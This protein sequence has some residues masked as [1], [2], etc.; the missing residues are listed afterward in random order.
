MGR[1]NCRPGVEPADRNRV[2]PVRRSCDRAHHLSMTSLPAQFVASLTDSNADA[3]F[4]CVV[5]GHRKSRDAALPRGWPCPMRRC[6]ACGLIQQSSR[7]SA[8]SPVGPVNLSLN[9]GAQ[10][11]SEAWTSAVQQYASCL[12]PLE[13]SPGRNLLIV[14]CGRGHLAALARSR[15][16]RVVALDSSPHA[17]CRAIEQFGLDARAGGLARHRE[18]L[19]RFDVVV[20]GNLE[21]SWDPAAVL[22]DTRTVLNTAGLVCVDVSDGFADWNPAMADTSRDSQDAPLNLFNAE[23]L[24]GLLRT[25]GLEMVAV[26]AGG[27]GSAP[28]LATN[29]LGVFRWIP[30]FIARWF[31]RLW[32]L[33][34]GGP[35][36]GCPRSAARDLSEAVAQI[37]A[38]ASRP[39]AQRGRANR[40]LAVATRAALAG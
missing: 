12:L 27:K 25:C 14:G 36:K 10:S 16:W 40:L 11:E 30:R 5:C 7:R 32:S 18:A 34:A 29:G 23:S 2:P 15:G 4:V 38:T 8:R 22:R 21:T 28:Q 17:V 31:S 37:E 9:G 35:A 33:F 39:T 20:C 19:G 1:E 26:H 6:D 3:A 24:E 13:S